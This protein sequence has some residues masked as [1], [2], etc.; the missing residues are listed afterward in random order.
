MTWCPRT[1]GNFDGGVLPSISSNSVWH[2]PQADTFTRISCSRGI[3]IGRSA[4]SKGNLVSG[5]LAILFST[6]AFI[7]LTSNK[8]TYVFIIAEGVV[9]DNRWTRKSI[10]RHFGYVSKISI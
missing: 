8:K 4:G 1:I 7:Q 9:R 3:G 6:M 5:R 2:T 10:E